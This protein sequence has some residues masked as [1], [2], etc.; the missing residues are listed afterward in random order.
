MKLD[1]NGV[2]ERVYT[3]QSETAN[4]ML[5]AKKVSIGYSKKED[6][7]KSH[8]IRYIWQEVVD[9]QNADIDCVLYGQSDRYRLK[10]E[11]RY[12]EVG[13]EDWYNWPKCKQERQELFFCRSKFCTTIFLLP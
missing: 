12:L 7:S 4:S 6:I 3:N 9:E 11:A 5:A 2:P 13:I 1:G 8:F 10:E